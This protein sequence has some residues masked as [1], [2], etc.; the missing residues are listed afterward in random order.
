MIVKTEKDEGSTLP[1]L[2]GMVVVIALLAAGVVDL[3][4]VYLAHRALYQVADSAALAAVTKLDAVGYYTTGAKDVVPT[5]DHD[6]IVASV[7]ARSELPESRVESVIDDGEGVSVSLALRISLP[8]SFL[9][10]HVTI[11]AHARALARAV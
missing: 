11:R 7:V 1:L 10:T 5:R 6:L 3:S 9:A 2:I 8:W 4:R